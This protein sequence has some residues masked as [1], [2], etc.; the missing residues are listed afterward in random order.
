[1]TNII[2]LPRRKPNAAQLELPRAGISGILHDLNKSLMKAQMA[3]MTA[4]TAAELAQ[5]LAE[6]HEML[7][8]ADAG[9]AALVEST[10]GWR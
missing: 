6:T 7:S 1:M 8:E 2:N 3:L 10:R 9:F 5:V 4:N